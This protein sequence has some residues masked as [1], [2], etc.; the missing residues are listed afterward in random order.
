MKR[1][2]ERKRTG[3]RHAFGDILRPQSVY[4]A[5]ASLSNTY[6]AT[7]Q[8]N[9]HLEG[10]ILHPNTRGSHSTLDITG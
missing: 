7:R 9:A 10:V 4:F 8:L 5:L 3:S 1:A 2:E 6:V